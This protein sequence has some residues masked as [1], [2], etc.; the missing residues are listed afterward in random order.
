MA[1]Q[2]SR[3][4]TSGVGHRSVRSVP[5]AIVIRT[6][7]VAQ[8]LARAVVREGQHLA[9]PAPTFGWS[10]RTGTSWTWPR[11]HW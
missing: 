10:L 3:V 9:I 7:R 2:A 5:G 1:K 11:D 6:H 8:A 4:S